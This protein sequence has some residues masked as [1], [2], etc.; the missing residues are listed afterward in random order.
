[1]KSSKTLMKTVGLTVLIL[2]V[3]FAAS[4]TPPPSQAEE[5]AAAHRLINEL[6]TEIDRHNGIITDLEDRISALEQQNDLLKI[7]LKAAENHGTILEEQMEERAK[8]QRAYDFSKKLADLLD[9]VFKRI[10]AL[11][12]ENAR[13]QE[14][15][16]SA[17]RNSAPGATSPLGSG[18]A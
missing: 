13:L 9:P 18:Q 5:L 16:L 15:L 8:V 10:Q 1:M 7:Q 17:T 2:W 14:A 12:E 4:A 11:K 6:T 3:I